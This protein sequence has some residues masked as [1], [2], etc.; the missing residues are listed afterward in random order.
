MEFS[1][2]DGTRFQSSRLDHSVYSLT[3]PTTTHIH[4]TFLFL[5]MQ[6]GKNNPEAAGSNLCISCQVA[7]SLQ[8]MIW[9]G[10]WRCCCL[11]A[12]MRQ[13]RKSY[14]LKLLKR[15]GLLSTPIQQKSFS[16]WTRTGRPGKIFTLKLFHLLFKRIPLGLMVKKQY[17]FRTPVN[18]EP[19]VGYGLGVSPAS[20]R[21]MLNGTNPKISEL[22]WNLIDCFY[23]RVHPICIFSL[24]GVTKLPCT[25]GL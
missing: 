5:Y 17:L 7:S 12:R 25:V 9:P 20:Y 11:E 16:Q 21:Y 3:L 1:C 23:W 13:E 18:Y 15:S 6:E 14:L 19:W 10:G 22:F 8:R 2:C 24:A 4:C